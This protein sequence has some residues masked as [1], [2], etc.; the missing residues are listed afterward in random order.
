MDWEDSDADPVTKQTSLFYLIPYNYLIPNTDA[1]LIAGCPQPDQPLSLWK[2]AKSTAGGK[3]VLNF[4]D[5]NLPGRRTG[6][7][8][9][10]SADAS[11]SMGSW[12]IIGDNIT[13]QFP[14]AAGIQWEEG[15]ALPGTWFYQVT[16]YH[17]VCDTE[18]PF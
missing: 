13:D 10:R 12:P 7:R 1:G 9:R 3:T 15:T 17:A 14:Y 2:V 18:G 4:T 5:P 16:A 11:L 8:V 6:Y